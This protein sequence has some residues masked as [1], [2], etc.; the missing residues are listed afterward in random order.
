M[1][2]PEQLAE[3]WVRVATVNHYMVG[4][5]EPYT[6]E[7]LEAAYQIL[8]DLSNA[9]DNKDANIELA[10]DLVNHVLNFGHK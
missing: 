9:S 7:E 2:R 6:I 8:I 3:A 4:I 10:L 5:V 1:N